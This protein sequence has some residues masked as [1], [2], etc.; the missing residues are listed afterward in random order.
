MKIGRGLKIVLFV[1]AAEILGGLGSLVTSPAVGGWYKEL[2]KPSF[3]PP[4]WLFGPAWTIL[5]ALMGV[6]FYLVYEK[7]L[8]NKKVKEAITVFII[9]FIFNIAW[10]FIFFGAKLPRLALLEIIIMWFLILLTMIKF[11]RISK[12]AALLLLPYLLWVTFATLLNY[13]IVVLNNF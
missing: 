9:Q 10:S 4:N 6:S 1:L 12:T 7:G 5:F 11:Y 8:K 3:N 13:S 2:V